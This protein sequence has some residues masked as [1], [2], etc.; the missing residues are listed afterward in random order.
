MDA[1]SA[2]VDII[3]KVTETFEAFI[4][5]KKANQC[6]AIIMPDSPKPAMVSQ[7]NLRDSFLY[8]IH[9]NMIPVAINIL[10]QTNGNASIEISAPSTAVNPQIKTKT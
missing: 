7:E 4:A 9:I 6:K 5:P 3:A 10:Y 2:P 1:N 8:A